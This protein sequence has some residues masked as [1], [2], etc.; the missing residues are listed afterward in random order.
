MRQRTLVLP[1]RS[2]SAPAQSQM[3]DFDPY[4]G[5]DRFVCSDIMPDLL[6][7]CRVKLRVRDGVFA[8]QMLQIHL[9]AQQYLAAFPIDFSRRTT[10]LPPILRWNIPHELGNSTQGQRYGR[11]FVMLEHYVY[12]AFTS[13]KFIRCHNS[14][15]AVISSPTTYRSNPS[16]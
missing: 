6:P 4:P 12:V 8:G 7:G 10:R 16:A 2:S 11:I 9:A 5:R 14:I 15:L 1:Y 13:S 3:Y